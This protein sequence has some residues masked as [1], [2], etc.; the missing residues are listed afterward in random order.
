MA[1]MMVLVMKLSSFA[2]SVHDG[3]RPDADLSPEQ[4]K[5]AVRS[6]PSLLALMG[7]AFCFNGVWVGPAIEFE[8]YAAFVDETGEFAHASISYSHALKV[9]LLGVGLFAGHTLLTPYVHFMH[10]SEPFFAAMPFWRRMAYIQ[11]SGMVVR[12]KYYGAWKISEASCAL[13]TL[14]YN[15]GKFDR[16]QNVDVLGV[17]VFFACVDD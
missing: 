6:H 12:A 3:A 11:L 5:F 8:S 10:C 1:A 14:A 4:R 7:Y 13:S 15:N 9:T 2:W 17:E 16:A